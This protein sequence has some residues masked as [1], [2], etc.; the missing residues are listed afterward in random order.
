[1][2]EEKI[3]T[4]IPTN[5]RVIDFLYHCMNATDNIYKKKAYQRAINEI[6]SYWHVMDTSFVP[7]HIGPSISRKIREFL[8]GDI[9]N[10]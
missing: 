9:I 5:Q 7:Q 10:S 2:S 3:T 4:H 1:M 6:H 8:E